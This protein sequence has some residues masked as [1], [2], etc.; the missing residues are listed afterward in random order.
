[1][2]RFAIGLAIL[3]VAIV[4]AVY[5]LSERTLTQRYLIPQDPVAIPTGPAAL[6]RGEHLFKAVGTCPTC[7]GPDG[8]G[9]VYADM[10]M[11][12]VVAGPNLTRGRGGIATAMTDADFVRAIRYGVRSDGTSLIMMPSEVFT[13]FTD[14]DLGALIAYVRQL[15]PIDR[16]VPTTRFRF[17][18]RTLL[19]LGR[20][21][22]LTAPKTHHVPR[23][24]VVAAE[25]STEYGR[26]LADVSGCHGCHGFGL[27]GGRVAGPPGLPPAA[28]LTPAG[29]GQW[30][31]ADFFRAIREGKRPDGSALDPFM[32]WP[33][34]AGMTDAELHA[35]WV[36][37]QS[38]PPKPSGNK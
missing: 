29:L 12:G 24:G 1:M 30:R 11:I 8:G 18:G 4:G 5:V 21:S 7:H 28:N 34:Y 17:L 2:R 27:S 15:P 33:T 25:A 35:L 31:E 22:I 6:T 19:A 9:F 16:V 26:Y 36:Y 23:G 20:L 14:A 38:V 3:V 10:G 32:P 37:L 13:F